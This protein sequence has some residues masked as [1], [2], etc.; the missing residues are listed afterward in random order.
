MGSAVLR[1]CLCV[2]LLTCSISSYGGT[3]CHTLDAAIDWDSRGPSEGGQLWS[4]WATPLPKECR[5]DKDASWQGLPNPEVGGK[6]DSIVFLKSCLW[7]PWWLFLFLYSEVFA[8]YFMGFCGL[9]YSINH[10]APFRVSLY[11]SFTRSDSS[12]TRKRSVRWLMRPG[13][14][15]WAPIDKSI[16]HLAGQCPFPSS[17]LRAELGTGRNKVW[18]CLMTPT[19]CRFRGGATPE[20]PGIL[21]IKQ[22]CGNGAKAR[23]HFLGSSTKSGINLRRP[24]TKT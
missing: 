18:K 19:L 1:G 21:E 6:T 11:A 15:C 9:K 13:Q 23:A 17:D 10:C 8:S 7:W 24:K 4:S 12:C 22:W 2:P 3:V 5:G 14:A 16:S 20:S